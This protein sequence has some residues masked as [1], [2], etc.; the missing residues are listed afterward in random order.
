[1][2]TALERNGDFSQTLDNQRTRIRFI[3]DPNLARKAWR[4][5]S[6]PAGAGCFA[7]NIIPQDRINPIGPDDAEHVPDAERD[8]SGRHAAVQLP[9][10]GHRREAA[11][12]QVLR[13]DW[14]VAPARR[15]TARLQ[16]GHE[17]CARGYVASGCAP[18]L[19]LHGNL[20]AD[21]ELV[22]HRHLRIVNT[23]LHTFNPT[24]VLEVT[25]GLN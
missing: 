11:A 5:T 15:S 20:A 22:R 3:S 2:P 17:V 4:A 25:V 14:N 13:V 9:V 6:T 23:L 7:G 8:R 18:D 21:A 16:F 24:T 19:F 12:D 10:R 1:M